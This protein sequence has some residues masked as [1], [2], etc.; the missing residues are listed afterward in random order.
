[1]KTPQLA[2]GFAASLVALSYAPAIRAESTATRSTTQ[3]TQTTQQPP[4]PSSTTTTTAAP[5]VIA[6]DGGERVTETRPNRALLSTGVGLFVISYGASVIGAAVSDRDADKNLFVPVVGPWMN[7][8]QRDCDVNPCGNNEDLNKAM[9]VTSGIVQGAGLILG[10]SSLFVP[11]TTVTRRT[12]SA[13]PEV[14]IT[15]LSFGAGA[16]LGAVGRF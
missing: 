16:G 8:A 3:T 14:R 12:A 7:L 1:M 13:E 4:S 15:P 5:I 2:I 6:T 10:L 11:E 9:I